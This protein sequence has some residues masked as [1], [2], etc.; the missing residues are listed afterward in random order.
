MR[1]FMQ[2]LTLLFL[3]LTVII[4]M[5][6][7]GLSWRA[8]NLKNELTALQKQI[9]DMKVLVKVL[10]GE[11][12]QLNRPERL[13]RLAEQHLDIKKVSAYNQIEYISQLP[14]RKEVAALKAEQQKTLKQ[15]QEET[16]NILEEN[17]IPGLSQDPINELML[18]IPEVKKDKDLIE[19]LIER[20]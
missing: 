19:E 11:W 2:R 9:E 3:L 10:E 15:E 6:T 13:K 12:S 7:M 1:L 17:V 8:D 14:T 16:N 18:E 4:A 5:F 20:E